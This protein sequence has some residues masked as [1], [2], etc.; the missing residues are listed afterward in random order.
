MAVRLGDRPLGAVVAD[1]IEGV[2]VANDLTG[3][4]ATRL[5]TLLWEAV[6]GEVTLTEQAA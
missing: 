6:S 5:R 3:G 4:D 1:M 2:V